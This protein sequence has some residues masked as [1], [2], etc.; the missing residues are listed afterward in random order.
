MTRLFF[1]TLELTAVFV[2]V[3]VL[4]YYRGIPNLPIPYILLTAFGAF[5][6][7]RRDATFSLSQLTSWG[8]FRPFLT[9]ILIRDA[10]CIVGL[11]IAVYLLAPQLLFSLIRRS[12][13]LWAL[14]FLLY[15]L[16]S[17]YPQELL[18]RAFFFHRYEPLFGR[19]RGMLLASALA[20]AFV[21]IIFRNWL[22]VGLCVIGGFL[23]SLTYQTSGSLLLACLDHVI[24]GNFLFTIGLGQFFY[25]GSRP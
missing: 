10:V 24:F 22:A 18:Y 23:F 14:V 5:L 17:V 2:V 7:L 6:L 25:H 11:G 19:G 20:F 4:I 12:P 8:N 15:P 3:P 9:A 1:L 13:W 16:L 21:H